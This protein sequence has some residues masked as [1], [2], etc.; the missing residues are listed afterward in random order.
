MADAEACYCTVLRLDSG[1]FAA[2]SNLGNVML[3]LGRIDD[4]LDLYEKAV[5]QRPDSGEAH[6]NLA[7]AAQLAGLEGADHHFR[8]ALR[9]KPDHAPAWEGLGL[10]LF[11]SGDGMESMRCLAKAL[12]LQPESVDSRVYLARGHL[13]HQQY[14]EAAAQ[15][16]RV[17]SLRP[18]DPRGDS[19][20]GAVRARQGKWASASRHFESALATGRFDGWA[21]FEHAKLLLTLGDYERGW[22]AYDDS[23]GLMGPVVNRVVNREIPAR[24]WMGESLAGQRIL[25]TAEQG[26]GD[27]IMFASVLPD[28][29]TES[30]QCFVECDIRLAP[31]L[32][33]SLGVETIGV[34]RRT[35]DWIDALPAH[36]AQ[37]PAFDYWVPAGS[38]P[39]YRRRTAA[40]FPR[41]Q[42]YLHADP[43]QVIDWQSRLAELGPGLRVG[44]TWR[45]GTLSSNRKSRSLA[46]ADLLPII[47][48]PGLQLH[49]LQHGAEPA[50]LAELRRSHGVR[51]NHWPGVTDNMDASAALVQT[52]DLV[53]T[54]CNYAVHLAGALGKEA[55]VMTPHVAEWRYGNE[56]ASM[57][58]YPPVRLMRQPDP[59]SWEPVIASMADGLRARLAAMGAAAGAAK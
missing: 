6:N 27:E 30:A 18:G 21:G 12:E 26:L 57:P 53:L 54:V 2:L 41:H 4:A 24:R 52:L 56:G 15:F 51:I 25:V 8:E 43:Q 3:D 47:G 31:L 36:L 10:C 58:W 40:E 50:E 55:W 29:A 28:I 38:L 13:L 11:G 1:N 5:I 46:L 16:S 34:E 7:R 9:L 17:Q 59:G 14:D 22:A 48:M 42:G 20:L 39:R 45:G 23:R 19:G 49:S 32:H 44:L 33:R 37:L 35:N